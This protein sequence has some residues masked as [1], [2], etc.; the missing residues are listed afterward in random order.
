MQE[1]S[2]NV[3]QDGIYNMLFV[4]IDTGD[5]IEMEREKAICAYAKGDKYD[6]LHDRCPDRC[7]NIS[8]RHSTSRLFMESVCP[9]KSWT[10]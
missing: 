2:H 9:Q 3:S 8:R 5:F 4:I 6:F 10:F 7:Q 1:V